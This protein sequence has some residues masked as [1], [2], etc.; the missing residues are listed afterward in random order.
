MSGA[1]N[2]PRARAPAADPGLEKA[3]RGRLKKTFGSAGLW[4]PRGSLVPASSDG[5][6]PAASTTALRDPLRGRPFRDDLRCLSALWARPAHSG[7]GA[8]VFGPARPTLF[9]SACRTDLAVEAAAR[10]G[11]HR[12][13]AAGPPPLSLHDPVRTRLLAG[14]E[15][16]QISTKQEQC[17]GLFSSL[18]AHPHPR[19]TNG[20]GSRRRDS[21][22]RVRDYAGSGGACIARCPAAGALTPAPLPF[23]R[24]VRSDSAAAA[25]PRPGRTR[26]SPGRA[27]GAH[28][29]RRRNRR[30]AGGACRARR[31][32]ARRGRS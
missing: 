15:R 31:G 2:P 14:G 3:R 11:R 32:C 1:R 24:G 19:R 28:R 10:V 20:R 9:K 17:Q 27:G 22:V 8:D 5:T 18:C 26:R 7:R 23:G 4:R 21:A 25:L 6:L 16:R 13:P 29:S 30:R 12:A